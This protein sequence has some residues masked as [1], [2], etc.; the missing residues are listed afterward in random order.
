MKFVF[1]TTEPDKVI[2]FLW[3]ALK[4]PDCPGLLQNILANLLKKRGDFRRAAEVYRHTIQTCRDPTSVDT[5]RRQL[6]RL[7]KAGLAP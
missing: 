4:Y 3:E 5:A 6:D 1:A 7:R 2:V